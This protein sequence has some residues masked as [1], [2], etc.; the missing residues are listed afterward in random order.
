MRQRS[1]PYSYVPIEKLHRLTT[2]VVQGIVALGSP[3]EYQRIDQILPILYEEGKTPL[4][5][6]LDNITDVRNIG[7]IARSA[8]CFGADAIIIP[9]Q[10]G[11]MIN[12]DAVVASAGALNSMRVCRESHLNEALEY[13][14]QSGV[15]LVACTEKVKDGL[16]SVDFTLPTAVIFGSEGVGIHPSVL[17]IVDKKI[18]I[19]MVGNFDSLNVSVATGIVLH[20]VA[21]IRNK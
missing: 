11:G 6:V 12:E 8:L 19:K 3:I 10:G 21:Q 7:G 5:V 14:Q 9:A 15:Q 18:R 2:N 17:A 4:F 1:I 13:L 16:E 20:Q